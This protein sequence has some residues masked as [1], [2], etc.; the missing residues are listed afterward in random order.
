MVL[1][2]MV[3]RC[4]LAIIVQYAGLDVD[5]LAAVSR[6]L[7]LLAMHRL[8]LCVGINMKLLLEL[9]P[10]K[11]PRCAASIGDD[12]AGWTVLIG[13]RDWKREVSAMPVHPRCRF[14]PRVRDLRL[15]LGGSTGLTRDSVYELTDMICV[16][17]LRELRHLRLAAPRQ[18]RTMMSG[19][20]RELDHNLGEYWWREV[21]GY[22]PYLN[23]LYVWLVANVVHGDRRR[24]LTRRRV[25]FV[26]QRQLETLDLDLR[27]THFKDP[28]LRPL[29]NAFEA[30]AGRGDY[31]L[32]S[33]RLE[34]GQL[35]ILPAG[36]PAVDNRG[37]RIVPVHW[38]WL[39]AQVRAIVRAGVTTLRLGLDG[40]SGAAAGLAIAIAPEVADGLVRLSVGLAKCA[41]TARD[42]ETFWPAVM[43]ALRRLELNLC[44]WE[45]ESAMVLC[46]GAVAVAP[47]LCAVSLVVSAGEA[48]MSQLSEE[49]LRST[50]FTEVERVTVVSVS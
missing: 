8:R 16:P 43:P 22:G 27:D 35:G 12:T 17:G 20:R 24:I 23:D 15:E 49:Q 40:V 33:V 50:L 6:P 21:Q 29:A 48:A 14:G 2:S 34:L 25:P 45:P 38:P 30:L 4:V 44:E 46:R 36:R 1:M 18:T 42:A 11:R 32:R 26:R 31:R 19:E 9:L 10:R 5:R 41:V 7:R 39:E 3:P 47:R 28:F 37:D 13:V